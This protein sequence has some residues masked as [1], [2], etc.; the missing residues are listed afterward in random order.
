MAGRTAYRADGTVLW[1]NEDV[2]DGTNAVG[3]FDDDPYP[4]IVLV[5]ESRVYLLE[6]DGR[7]KWGP[8]AIP[9]GSDSRRWRPTHGR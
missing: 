4:E 2:T 7:L 5:T 8:V 6:H 9:G 1:H 3:N